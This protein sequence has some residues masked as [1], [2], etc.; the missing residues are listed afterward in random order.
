MK[1]LLLLA[2]LLLG[3]PL[4]QAQ[5]AP[6]Q[7]DPRLDMLA[8]L[9]RDPA[10]AVRVEALRA[11]A[12][13]PT[14][15]AAALAL[16]VLDLPMDPTLDYA[17]WLTINDLAEPWIAA[18]QGGAWK[19]EGREKQLEFALRAL[20]PEQAGRVLADVL[21]ARPP[22]RDGAGPWIE[23]IG[24]AGGPAQ[25]GLLLEKAAGGGFDDGASVR[26]LRALGD[27]HRL[28]RLRPPGDPA[29]L[30]GLLDAASSAVA[31]AAADLAGEWKDVGGAFPKLAEL[32]ARPEADAG[33]RAAAIA[34]LRRI[35]GGEAT[36]A[37][38][39]LAAPGGEALARRRAAAALLALDEPAG[40]QAVAAVAS[41]TADEAAALELWRDALAVK[42]AGP[43]LADALA[44]VKLSAP[45]ARAGMRAAREGGRSEVGLVAALAQ[46]G[47]LAA[48]AAEAT[49]GMV[50]ELAAR[51]VE[52]GDPHRG[53]FVYRRPALACVTCH[54]LGGVG[55]RVGPDMTSIGASAPAD[56]LVESLLLPH[57]KIKEGYHSVVVAT[58]DGEELTGTLARETPEEIFLRNAAGQEVAVAKANVARREIGTLSLMPAGLLDP[59]T[60]QEK[61]DL[62]AF[63]TRL[64]KPGDFDAAQG[65]VARVWRLA[66]TVH[67]DA[68]AGQEGWPLTAPWD[69]KRWTPAAAL[70]RGD[71]SRAALEEAVRGQFWVG[72]LAVYAATEITT[73]QP[74]PVNFTL[75][76]GPGAELWV[77]GQKAGGPGAVRV[78]LPAGTHRVLVKLDPRRIPDRIRLETRDA[79]FGME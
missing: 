35:G 6:A 28:R 5:L 55:G 4:V 30:G 19:P 70:V 68:Q 52:A 69:D 13:I 74:G 78:E 15:E 2:A 77:A 27:A 16:G 49:A 25:L 10:P 36:R 42:G 57:A 17:L 56:Y 64:G 18:L 60:E 21:A 9:A 44:A 79:V 29:A 43:A 3:R 8:K 54:A 72:K 45:A 59:L 48:D 53:E 34:A 50:R 47:G 26:A 7:A 23:L 1:H 31:T 66:Q 22:A 63:L 65:G 12:K 67:T 46:A 39:R 62:V 76:A 40:A 37:L 38:A 20:R 71:L 73:A 58:Q 61:L 14:A 51:A 11:L 24:A 32:A 33:A 41:E 75:A